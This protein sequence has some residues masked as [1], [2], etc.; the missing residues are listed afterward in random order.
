MMRVSSVSGQHTFVATLCFDRQKAGEGWL[1]RPF[2]PLNR[3]SAD[4]PC[5][6]ED[7]CG[8]VLCG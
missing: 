5:G 6:A 8:G 3:P 4:A 2:D 7:R 1:R